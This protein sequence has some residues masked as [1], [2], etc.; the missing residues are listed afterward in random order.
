[1][2]ALS[3]V[4]GL[5]T[6][7]AISLAYAAS[8][9][10]VDASGLATQPSYR[11]KLGPF[12]TPPTRTSGLLIK[13]RINHGP[14]LR[15]LLDSG[16]QY[17]VLNRRVAGKLGCTG[18]IDFDLV[19][20]GAHSPAT[21]KQLYAGTMEIGD[22]T[23]HNLPL[24]VTDSD[25]PNGIQ[26]ALPL[27]IFA[28]FLIR[29]DIPGKSLELL[30]YPPTPTDPNGTLKALNSNHLL[31]VKGTV[32]G[33]H[34]GYFLLDT[35][36]SYMAISR[37]MARQL[38]VSEVSASRIELQG[39]TGGIDAPVV[40][41]NVRLRLGTREFET[42]P[43]VAVDLSTASLYHQVEVSG[44]LGYPALRGSVLTLNYRDGFVRIDRR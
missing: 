18:G 21:V 6:P 7:L 35:G 22:L 42:G 8:P 28:T 11:F 44:L 27:A 23:L 40:S 41:G 26:G 36:A 14:E 3:I 16:T 38:E 39:G 1:M 5:L 15:L 33:T 12:V 31:F 32:N 25:L 34:E 29:L 10:G 24:L 9:A 43:V 13:A 2:R 17:V 19:G 30:P 37:K 20:A 4:S